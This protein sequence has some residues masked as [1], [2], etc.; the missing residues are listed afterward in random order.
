M[1][2]FATVAL[3]V[4][5]AAPLAA[6]RGQRLQVPPGQREA[7][8]AEVMNNFMNRYQ[9]LAALTPEQTDKFRASMVKNMQ[10]Q[11]DL[12]QR[13]RT[14]LQALEFQMR[15]GVAANAD[16]V[17]K[18]LDAL[19][20]ARQAQVDQAKAEQRDYATYLNPVQRAQL[21]IQWEQLKNRI[22]EVTRSRMQ[23]PAQ[24]PGN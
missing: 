20:A 7:L 1:R 4:S 8:V 10:A 5:V 6:Q 24:G 14:V 22:Q 13:E 2:A 17:G 3:L 11:K 21:A 9:R 19:T 16:S 12:T 15:P 23:P 18:L